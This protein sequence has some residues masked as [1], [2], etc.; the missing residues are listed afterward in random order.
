M[1]MLGNVMRNDAYYLEDF[2][3]IE[4]VESTYSDEDAPVFPEK[5]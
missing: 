1:Q 3:M 2:D 4:L 5:G